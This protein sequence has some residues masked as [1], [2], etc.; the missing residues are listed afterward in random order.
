MSYVLCEVGIPNTTM[1]SY[2]SFEQ[3]I[4]LITYSKFSEPPYR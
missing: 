4:E 1:L 3:G 2:L